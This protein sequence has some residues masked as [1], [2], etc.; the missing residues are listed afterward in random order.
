MFFQCHPNTAW[1]AGL[2]AHPSQWGSRIFNSSGR[3]WLFPRSFLHLSQPFSDPRKTG[4]QIKPPKVDLNEQGELGQVLPRA[5]PLV[6]YSGVPTPFLASASKPH[7]RCLGDTRL[8]PTPALSW[9]EV[10]RGIPAPLLHPASEFPPNLLFCP[11]RGAVPPTAGAGCSPAAVGGARDLQMGWADRC[12]HD[13]KPVLLTWH[14][15]PASLFFPF[16][17]SPSN[18]LT[19]R[20]PAGDGQCLQQLLVLQEGSEDVLWFIPSSSSVLYILE[21]NVSEHEFMSRRNS[22]KANTKV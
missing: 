14:R 18:D 1:L 7:T 13:A 2:D 16:F 22:A 3:A 10:A 9:P 6:P 8:S 17:R 11:W 15:V 20:E 12:Q 21:G 19:R 4:I 5:T